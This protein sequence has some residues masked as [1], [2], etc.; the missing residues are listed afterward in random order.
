MKKLKQYVK[1]LEDSMNK[2]RVGVIVYA[3]S[4]PTEGGGHTYYHNLLKGINRFNFSPDIEIINIVFYKKTIPSLNLQKSSIYIRSA[5]KINP[6][7]KGNAPI[8]HN[9]THVVS[10]FFFM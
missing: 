4:H 1:P 6:L 3:D 7:L 10:R 5:Y 2:L 8:G 9:I